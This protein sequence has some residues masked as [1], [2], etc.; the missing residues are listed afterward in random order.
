[1]KFS[2]GAFVALSLLVAQVA[3]LPGL[4]I[5]KQGGNNGGK[6]GNNGG[7]GGNNGGNNGT[8]GG[9]NGTQN[10]GGNGGNN[11]GNN[12]GD[13]QSSLTLDPS[14]IA[15]GFADDGQDVPEAG[16]VAS[17]TST[18]NFINFCATVPNLPITNGKQI[19]TGSCNP[20][21]MGEIPSTDN[22]PSA[23]FVVPKNLD[24]FP[25]NTAFTIQMAIQGMETGF[26]VNAN[27][28][29]FA[30][31]QQLNDAGQITGHSHVVIE[32][33]DSIDST[34]PSDPNVFAFFKGLNDKA[35]G[36]IL[37][38]NVTNG[39]PA[40]TYKLSSINTAAN[41]QPCLVPIAQHGS[42]D[43]AV[44]FTVGDAA[45]QA[46]SQVA[47]GN[48]NGN[49]NGNN[50]NNGQNGQGASDGGSAQGGADANANADPADNGNNNA[51]PV[52]NTNDNADPAANTSDNAD[53]AANTNDNADPTDNTS[54]NADPTADD[55]TNGNGD[56]GDN[57]NNGKDNNSNKS[58]NAGSAGDNNNNAG[59]NGQ[60]G[61]QGGQDD[62]GDGNKG[63]N[64][65]GKGKRQF[66]SRSLA[67]GYGRQARGLS[68][69]QRRV[70]QESS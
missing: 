51:D 66:M 15:T 9:N 31:P 33:I 7:K 24:N 18:N 54:D 68:R 50:D 43:D 21:P 58:D 42:L 57:S 48:G 65:G 62:G 6:G 44:Y 60:K 29:Y 47:G 26:F 55:N 27:E 10:D 40:G 34:K 20:A 4:E 67:A 25:E 12:G 22:M 1:M 8:N 30:A 2:T 56:N 3:A 49:G 17:L 14:V 53:P 61:G 5:R 39:L 23:K 70:S 41:H 63:G 52:A 45:Q 38:A 35:S 46:A 16:Q 19:K 11:G 64:K 37:T 13:I 28:N 36:G 59:G 32:A 69:L